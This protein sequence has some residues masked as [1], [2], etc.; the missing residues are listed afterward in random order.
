[1]QHVG[2]AFA[3]WAG[4]GNNLVG[5]SRQLVTVGIAP[6]TSPNTQ[7]WQWNGCLDKHGGTTGNVDLYILPGAHGIEPRVQDDG[8]AFQFLSSHSG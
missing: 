3:Y 7:L 2:E 5:R 1:M 8:R 6:N 4:C